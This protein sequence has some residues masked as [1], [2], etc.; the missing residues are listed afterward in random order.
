ML[1]A[2]DYF[3]DA[4]QTFAPYYIAYFG[5]QLLIV[6]AARLYLKWQERCI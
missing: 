4:V 2:A 5:A 3:R 1:T 6:E